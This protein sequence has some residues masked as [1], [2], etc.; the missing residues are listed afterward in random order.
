MTLHPIFLAFCLAAQSAPARF[1]SP[2]RFSVGQYPLAG[3]TADL[4]GD[5]ALDL[6]TADANVDTVSLLLGNGN[7][8]FSRARTYPVGKMPDAIAVGDLDGDGHPDVAVANSG[9]DSIS[10]LYGNGR[11]ALSSSRD[12]SVG[13]YPSWIALGDLN[14]DG[15]LDIVVANS[16]SNSISVIYSKGKRSHHRPLDLALPEAT[17]PPSQVA[18]ADL[19]RD[20]W[21]DIAVPRGN[22]IQILYSTP[23]GRFGKP[24]AIED[25]LAAFWLS[26]MDMN[27]DG[28]PDLVATDGT[29]VRVLYGD[30]R[31][32]FAEGPRLDLE[33]HGND[34]PTTGDLD[35][36]GHV[37][38]VVTNH[39]HNSLTVLLSDGKGGYTKNGVFAVGREACS[40]LVADF[41][42]DGHLD[43][44][45]VNRRGSDV[46]FLGNDGHGT[47]AAPRLFSPTSYNNVG[48]T[49]VDMNGD[50]LSDLVTTDGIFQGDGKGG[51]GR[52]TKIKAPCVPE[53]YFEIA[54]VA[55]GDLDGDGNPDIVHSCWQTNGIG[56]GLNDGH[57]GSAAG[58]NL[59]IGSD[60]ASSVSSA[61]LGDLDGDGKLDLIAAQ[62]NNL[63]V[64]L[65][66][67]RGGFG[68]ATAY[69][70]GDPSGSASNDT[71]A[72]GDLDRDGHLDVTVG[73]SDTATL[74]IL[75]GDG[76]GSFGPVES[77]PIGGPACG[78]A[79]R[80]LNGDGL[81]DAAAVSFDG[82]NVTALLGDGRGK[83]VPT[84][85]IPLDE[86]PVQVVIGDFNDDGHADL[87]IADNLDDS[88]TL[89]AGDGR[90]G[91]GVPEKR[92]VGYMPRDLS[93]SD[94]NGDG[95]T[96][97]VVGSSTNDVAVLLNQGPTSRPSGR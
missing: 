5:G 11:G 75:L 17:A 62:A 90:G 7:G 9:S 12:I 45:T 60:P 50:G 68:T 59:T 4:N 72:L 34:P 38:I 80:D 81:L 39:G 27:G 25:G 67:G 42:R 28:A 63:F 31:R 33:V 97:L 20:G 43:L 3:A 84:T 40:P 2:P 47:F 53:A 14:R 35:G 8:E 58:S 54:S 89:I 6:V 94:L 93:A 30:G 23:G 65:G 1:A 55:V 88:V 37:D 66:D 26:V 21:L 82:S 70:L 74:S 36:D 95:F 91:F 41:D 32:H 73:R 86:G 16:S 48:I 64:L 49:L 18:L 76:H 24:R 15:R 13:K 96:D 46:T 19:D 52:L 87:A 79:L 10:I 78:L 44:V 71:I 77:F 29:L 61:A 22:T 83:L 57:G 92:V 85:T 51:F 69:S 56:I